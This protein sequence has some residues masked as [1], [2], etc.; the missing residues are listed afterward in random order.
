MFHQ[1]FFD[2]SE[3]KTPENEFAYYEA[4]LKGHRYET[5]ISKNSSKPNERKDDTSKFNEK[6][7]DSLLST[8][9]ITKNM[10]LTYQRALPTKREEAF[11]TE[12]LEIL[13]EVCQRLGIG[14]SQLSGSWRRGTADCYSD[15]DFK[16]EVDSAIGSPNSVV[17]RASELLGEI[18]REDS[19]I[20]EFTKIVDVINCAV[21]LIVLKAQGRDIDRIIDLAFVSFICPLDAVKLRD[22][23][24]KMAIIYIK[25]LAKERGIVKRGPWIK[26]PSTV[27]EEIV[28]LAVNHWRVMND[29]DQCE[30]E[31]LGDILLHFCQLFCSEQSIQFG[32][33]RWEIQQLRFNFREVTKMLYDL[34]TSTIQIIQPHAPILDLRRSTVKA[35][36]GGGSTIPH[37]RF[38]EHEDKCS[39]ITLDSPTEKHF[40]SS[41]FESSKLIPFLL[42]R[43]DFS[44]PSYESTPLHTLSYNTSITSEEQATGCVNS[45]IK[46]IH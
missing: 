12:F 3:Q 2:Q 4:P 40:E 27:M 7:K 19:H 26:I 32:L 14:P 43:N 22:P 11:V 24:Q 44:T 16:V 30:E 28:V 20:G 17:D 45:L 36:C 21:P 34:A 9:T 25:Q 1:N 8:S 6:P 31:H 10:V 37:S 41:K 42:N 23:I 5:I 46:I 15:I 33:S 18:L 35:C 39:S 29:V 38:D 13:G